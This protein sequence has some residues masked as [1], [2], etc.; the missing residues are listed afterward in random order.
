MSCSIANE[1]SLPLSPARSFYLCEYLVCVNFHKI[2]FFFDDRVCDNCMKQNK[3]SE[4][5]MIHY[6]VKT[7][8]TIWFS[9][10]N[11]VQYKRTACEL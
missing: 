3:V 10:P 11:I 1:R 6:L 4:F 9:C 8:F 5:H 2:M 7:W